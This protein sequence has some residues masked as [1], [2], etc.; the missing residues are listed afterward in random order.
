MAR[1]VKPQVVEIGT[2]E[3]INDIYKKEYDLLMA[4]GIVDESL[5]SEI[6]SCVTR[7]KKHDKVLLA[8]TTYGGEANFAFRIAR[9]LQTAYE[10]FVV[11]IPSYCK[12]AGTLI[13]TGARTLIFALPTGEIGPLDV[14]VLQR[15]EIYGRRS[16]L[17]THAALADLQN[18]SF[19]IF[20]HF[21]LGIVERSMG[22][23]SFKLAA[24]IAAKSASQMLSPLYSQINPEILGQDARNLNVAHEYSIRLNRK[25]S[26][27]GASAIQ[28]LVHGYPSHDFVIDYEEAKGIFRRV[29]RG[30]EFLYHFLIDNLDQLGTPRTDAPFVEMSRGTSIGEEKGDN[31]ETS[32]VEG[33]PSAENDAGGLGGGGE[34][35]A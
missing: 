9:Y 33:I 27:L 18:H 4:N 13:A 1:K 16:G 28:R 26:N 19:Q 12:S 21:A 14:Q 35:A 22:A 5:Y 23:V 7:H 34:A 10:D 6:I 15:D 25:F 17:T 3:E 32:Q 8:L 31:D 24:E 20:E 11:F 2:N 29:E 30:T